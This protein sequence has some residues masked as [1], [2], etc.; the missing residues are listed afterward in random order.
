MNRILAIDDNHVN[1]DLIKAVLSKSIPECNVFTALSGKEGINLAKEVKPNAILL[2]IMMPEMNGFEV[3]EALKNDEP[4]RHIPVLL[5]SA[6]MQTSQD[7]IKGLDIGAEALLS[8]PFENAELIS[9]VKVLLRI[10]KAEDLLRKKNESLELFIKN[11]AEEINNN[12]TRFLQISEYAHEFFW[13]VD[14]TGKFTYVSAVVE[15][16]LGEKSEEIIGKKHIF[17]FFRVVGKDKTK[18]TLSDIFRNRSYYNNVEIFCL[19][20]ANRKIWLTISGFPIYDQ[21]SN[22]IG[23]R[24]V[25]HDITRR[26]LAE[27]EL[28]K[29]LRQIKQDHKKLKQLNAELDMAEEKERRRIAE[30]LHDGIGQLLSIARINLS[31]LQNK[32]LPDDIQKVIVKSSELLSEAIVRSRDLTYDLS[33]PILYELGLIP[34]IRWKLNQI[35]SNYKIQTAVQSELN[36]MDIKSDTRILLYRIISELLVNVT[37]HAHASFVEVKIYED[38]ENYYITVGD[39][40]VGFNGHAE[41]VKAQKDGGYGLYSISER[42]DSLQGKLNIESKNNGAR[43]TVS[44]PILNN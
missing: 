42:L 30:Y 32:K 41:A 37:K 7:R 23:Y 33:P 39:N 6:Y 17:D 10:N 35:E 22:F 36:K 2:D 20:K 18:K 43:V 25:T 38:K 8:K 15:N 28:N 12:E 24:G 9:Q 44:I 5:V 11:Q 1:L 29:S 19:D 40:G 16:I 14:V 13:E 31:S 21:E 26:R 4:T 3:C 27:E 34:A